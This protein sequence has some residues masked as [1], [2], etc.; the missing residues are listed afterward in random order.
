VSSR[1]IRVA[2]EKLINPEIKSK[3]DSWLPTI[4]TGA[5]AVVLSDPT[6]CLSPICTGDERNGAPWST[7]MS[8]K[9]LVRSD[10]LSD[11]GRISQLAG[12]QCNAAPICGSWLDAA[13]RPLELRESNYYA[14]AQPPT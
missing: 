7:S 2:T 12:S 14:V 1:F 4:E 5:M 9:R 10:V 8:R 6:G 3:S 11:I 13:S